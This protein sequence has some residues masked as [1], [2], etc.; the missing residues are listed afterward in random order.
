VKWE[1]L[2]ERNAKRILE[3]LERKAELVGLEQ[4]RKSYGLIAKK[5]GEKETLRERGYLVFELNDFKVGRKVL[6]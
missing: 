3:K 6:G 2:S 5:I 1:E 4:W